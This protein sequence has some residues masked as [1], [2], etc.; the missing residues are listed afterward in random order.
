M[1]YLKSETWLGTAYDLTPHQIWS[2]SVPQLR[3]F[4][5]VILPSPYEKL[6]GKL[7][8][9]SQHA[10]RIRAKSVSEIGSSAELETLSWTFC[11]PSPKW[12]TKGSE[13]M[14]NLASIFDRS[15]LWRLVVQ[16]LRNMCKLKCAVK[17]QM[18]ALCKL[19][20]CSLVHP[21]PRTQHSD[22]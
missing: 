8:L 19:Q 12:G 4:G 14:P 3:E 10:Q 6:A 20:I 16:K 15:R 22:I 7:C 17:A 13:N 5:I 2:R 21:T 18:I 11:P 9:I 1:T